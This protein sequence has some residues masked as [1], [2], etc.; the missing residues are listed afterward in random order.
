MT[1]NLDDRALFET[2]TGNGRPLLNLI[3]LA[4]SESGLFTFSGDSGFSS[5]IL[6]HYP[7]GYTKFIHVAAGL[8]AWFWL[9]TNPSALSHL[10]VSIFPDHFK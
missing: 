2:L 8:W 7:I 9:S 4:L 3:G 5:A 6:V 1:K 10:T